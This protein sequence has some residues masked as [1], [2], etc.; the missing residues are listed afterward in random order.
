MAAQRRTATELAPILGVSPSTA[1]RRLKHANLSFDE[2]EA[3]AGWLG[4]TYERLIIP[5]ELAYSA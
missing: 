4:V 1:S 5:A 3:I 2:V